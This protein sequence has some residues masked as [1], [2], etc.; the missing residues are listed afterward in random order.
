MP[1]F[2]SVEE[3]SRL[4]ARIRGKDTKPELAMRR[5]LLSKGVKSSSHCN[6]PGKPDFLI[7]GER[8]VVFV[9]GAFWHGRDFEAKKHKLKPF[10][11]DK[12]ANN[13]RRD[14]KNDRKL[15]ALGYS[16]VHVWED[17]VPKAFSKIK[18]AIERK[19][20]G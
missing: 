5:L 13:M 6:L 11:H 14:R 3:R 1:D 9:D 18:R 20:H 12:I 2:L 8:V 15:R 19:Y 17:E 16:I 10:W 4:M 7:K